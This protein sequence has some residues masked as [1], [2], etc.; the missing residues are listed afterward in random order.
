MTMQPSSDPYYNLRHSTAHLMAQAVGELFPG[1]KYAIGP[2]I[3]D[4][5]YYD[6][7]LPTP[8][9]EED[10]RR[11]EEVMHK[12]SRADLPIV[13]EEMERSAAAEFCAGMG[14]DYKVELIR[15]LPEGETI[16]FYRQGDW[17]DLCRGP[18]VPST[19]ALKHFK[20]L[21][22]AGA[23]WR[24]SEKNKMLTRIYGTAWNTEEELAEYL[25]RLEEARKRDH[26]VLGRELGL[27]MFSNEVGSG[28]PLWLPKG[29]TLRDTMQQFLQPEQIR[30]GY[31]PVV[32]PNVASTK[33]FAKSGHLATYRDKM[34]PIMEDKDS[35]DEFLLK[36]MNCPF[37]IEIYASEL[38][39]Y[40]D[41]PVR[42]A[43]FGTV[44]RYEQSG[45]LN[46]MLRVRGFTQDDAHLFCTPE[47]LGAEFKAVVDLTLFVLKKLGLTDYRARVGTR[48]PSS[49]K[50]VGG[51]DNWTAAESA[52]IQ[53][54]DEMGMQYFVSEGDAA[55]YGPKLDL[56]VRDALGREWQMGTVQV[57]YNLPERFGLEYVGEDG[58]K[59]RPVMIH[60]AP[61]GSLER[62][63]GLLVEHYAGAFPFWLAPVQVAILP[64]TDA[65]AEYAAQVT[66]R[67]RMQGFRAQIDARSERVGKKI[68]EAE[69]QKV[70]Y[71]LV[72][73]RRD[74]EAGV[75][76]VRKRGEGDLGAMSMEEVLARFVTERD[77]LP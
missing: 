58:S 68:A 60:R 25:H 27:F 30:R 31:Q 51:D 20:L 40:R 32:T 16:S 18:H 64:I 70:P 8:I 23:Y 12:Y 38:R 13:R 28:L 11:I 65:Q 41:L 76:S 35:G 36:P 43:E 74:V 19:G 73:G 49:S 72:M 26:R 7:D 59:H 21:S 55:F 17:I 29:A 24:G 4:G 37:H 2:P 42:Y 67:L 10:L 77:T 5:F 48:D 22:I 3:E 9:R 71:M 61:F 54:V 46:G 56:L 39:S 57:D 53:A 14:Q 62:M 63:I 69:T 33:L 15:D 6:F 34:F 52:I 47:Q 1:V 75:V 44:Y 50:Y 66:E 45:E